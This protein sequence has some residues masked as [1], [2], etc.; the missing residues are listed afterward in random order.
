[1]VLVVD[2]FYFGFIVDY[3][4]ENKSGILSFVLFLIMIVDGFFWISGEFVGFLGK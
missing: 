2:F 4:M 3:Y 1:M